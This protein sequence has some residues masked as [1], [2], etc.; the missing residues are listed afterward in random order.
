MKACPLCGAQG[1]RRLFDK[2]GQH[3]DRCGQCGFRFATAAGNANL[4]NA[5]DDFEPAYRQYLEPSAVDDRNHDDTIAWIERFAKLDASAAL[6]D[7]GTGS[8]KFLRHVRKV[9]PSATCGVEPSA[10][11]YRAYD[12]GAIG[13][14]N[15]TVPA[16]AET[17]TETFQVV[18]ALDVIEHVADPVEFAKGLGR[19]VAPGGF[20]FL[21]TPDAGS[22]LPATLGRFWHHYNRY[23]FSLLDRRTLARLAETAGFE[24][25]AFE[26][27]P[28]RVALSYVRSYI[29]DFFF[30]S[31]ASPA[32]GS[33]WDVPLNLFDIMSAVWRKPA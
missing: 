11:L 3:Y 29:G 7:V 32:N 24:T 18:T 27:R 9:R 5:I 22:L 13:V 23:H 14:V 21:S 25:V 30:G 26:H 8:G 31:S 4:D 28:K 1:T 10:A 16:F 6:L 15:A 2:G 19:L 12:L 17:A 33:G 20:L